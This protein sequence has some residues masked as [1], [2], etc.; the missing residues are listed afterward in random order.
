[1]WY[2][3]LSVWGCGGGSRWGAIPIDDGHS[4]LGTLGCWHQD[5]LCSPGMIVLCVILGIWVLWVFFFLC[6]VGCFSLII[7]TSAVL[8]VL[9]ACVL[10]FCIFTCLVQLSMFH[11]ERCSRNILI[12]IIIIIFAFAKL[13]LIHGKASSVFFQGCH[14]A[15]R[16]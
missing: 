1:M 7:W 14:F 4:L 12:M 3:V 11:V 8:S 6:L 10:F 9:Y 16:L 5:L 2:G 15:Y 13:L